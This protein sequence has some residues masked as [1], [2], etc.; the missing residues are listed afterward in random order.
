MFVKAREEVAARREALM[1][2][3]R[4]AIEVGLPKGFVAELEEILL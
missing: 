2:A 1:G 3:L 4:V